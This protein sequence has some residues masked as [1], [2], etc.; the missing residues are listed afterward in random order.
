M[1]ICMSTVRVPGI[2]KVMKTTLSFSLITAA[3]LAASAEAAWQRIGALDHRPVDLASESISGTSIASSSGIGQPENLISDD[4][5][6]VSRVGTGSSELVV[7]VGHLANIHLAAIMNDGVEGRL[8]VSGSVDQKTWNNLG[9]AVFT[10][11]DREVAI[12]FASSQAK[13]VRLQ[14]DLSKG[15]TVRSLSVYGSTT[16]REFAVAPGGPS[17][18]SAVNAGGGLGGAQIVYIDPNPSGSDE[19]A[20]K[21]NRFDF[22]ESPDRFRTVIYDF[23]S[24]RFITEV[25]SVHSARPVR[26]YA[27]TFKD[28]QF[29]EKE[30]WRGRMSFDPSVFETQKPDLVVDDPQGV[31]YVKGTLG[32]AV[33]A[34]YVALRWEPDFNPPRFQVGRVAVTIKSK[35]KA[36][37]QPGAGTGAGGGQSGTDGSD[38]QSGQT[39]GDSAVMAVTNPFAFTSGGFGGGG[40]VSNPNQGNGNNN[41]TPRPRPRPRPRSP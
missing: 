8:A 20:A 36:S 33:S 32:K 19:M 25:G 12:K 39:V 16:A 23:G 17:D 31:G 34:R 13:Y 4:V 1:L 37:F 35:G 30:D 24:D 28:K 5:A 7:N 9:E 11:A 18:S 22:P 29:P 15:G 21:Y 26:F 2:S 40:S 6:L 3:V 41:Q 10:P 38:G 14:F 27:Y